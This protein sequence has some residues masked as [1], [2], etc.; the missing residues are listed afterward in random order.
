[1]S[2]VTQILQAIDQGDPHAAEQ[3]LPL[4]YD[5]LRRLA[6][7]RLAEEKPGQTLQPTAL[8]HDHN[9]G[10]ATLEF[11]INI[12]E[13]SHSSIFWTRGDSADLNRFNIFVTGNVPQPFTGHV[14]G[15]DYRDPSGVLHPL[16]GY[17]LTSD[18]DPFS[19]TPGVW[20]HVGIT[21]S[22]DT[23]SFY[24]DGVLIHS[25]VD[26]SPNLP[27]ATTWTLS[28]RGGTTNYVG[29]I[30][31]IRTADSAFGPEGFM[32]VPAPSCL[33]LWGTGLVSLLGFTGL[34]RSSQVQRFV[35]RLS[36]CTDR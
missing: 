21:R 4:V 19:L 3:L 9:P 7:H 10:D 31:E 26:A 27:T 23:Y 18:E 6:A 24:K 14:L 30:D 33:T 13:Q 22:G 2:D 35:R 28:G 16:L 12:E 34:R 15:M 36:W 5:E 1:M 20:T 25:T 29:L 17:G 11:W 32:T 8:V